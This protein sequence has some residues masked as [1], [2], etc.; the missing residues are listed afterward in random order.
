MHELSIAMDL[1]DVAGRQ[2]EQRRVDV[3]ALHVKLG[4]LSGVVKESLASA[5]EIAREGTPL[6]HAR[7]EI[8][9]TP[10]LMECPVCHTIRPVVSMQELVCTDCGSPAKSIVGG[11]ELELFALEIDE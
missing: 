8:E 1:I 6:E 3:L 5:F 10:I 4:P 7:L 11:R 9:E 2:A